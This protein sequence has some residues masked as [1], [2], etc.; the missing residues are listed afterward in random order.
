M[1]KRMFSI[2]NRMN[3]PNNNNNKIKSGWLRKQGGMVKSWHRR[4]FVLNGNCL[5]YF[6]REDDI[7][8][9]GNLY[10]PGNK[11]IQHPANPDEP[12]KFLMEI[13]P[14]WYMQEH[15]EYFNL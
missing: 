9:L 11:I 7:K 1:G 12:D 6:A 3:H 2:F 8:T 10:L 5:F 13:V 15:E 4:W 14:G